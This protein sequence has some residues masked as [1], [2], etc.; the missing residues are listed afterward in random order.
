MNGKNLQPI[1]LFPVELSFRIEERESFPDKQKLKLVI[2]KTVLQEM[3]KGFKWK[4]N[5]PS[6]KIGNYETK[7]INGKEKHILK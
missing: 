3:L 1:I 6:V 5:P 7:K 2:T 4:K